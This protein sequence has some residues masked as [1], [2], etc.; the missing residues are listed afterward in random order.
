MSSGVFAVARNVFDHP[1]FEG[2]RFTEREAW[3]WLI[4][5]AAWKPKRVRVGTALVK[6]ERGQCAFSVRF[7]AQKWGWHRAKVERFL[8]RLKT[9]TMI[10]T[11]SETGVTVITICNYNEYQRVS[12]PTKTPTETPSETAARQ[13]RDKEEDTESTED[14]EKE[15]GANAPT[16]LAF[17]GR[18]I[19]LK[20]DQ[21]ERWRKAYPGVKDMLAELTKAD[22][23]YS[24]NPPDDGKWFFKVSKWL[25]KAH[26]DAIT[27][28]PETDWER[29]L[30]RIQA[31]AS[32]PLSPDEH[33]RWRAEGLS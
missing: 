22:D 13:Q 24:E 9:E 18:I 10:E 28:Q 15:G 33:A 20:A 17:V 3:I 16:D 2:E 32:K 27:P 30:K 12:L 6:L 29:T 26:R 11:A 21:F 8:K 25:E 14:K 23:Y 19:R 4:G 31:E 7:L 1:I 5:E